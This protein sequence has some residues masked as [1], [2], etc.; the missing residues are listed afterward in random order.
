MKNLFFLFV[1]MLVCMNVSSFGQTRR[2]EIIVDGFEGNKPLKENSVVIVDYPEKW[3]KGIWEE[4]YKGETRKSFLKRIKKQS[5]E[6]KE[7]RIP[8]KSYDEDEDILLVLPIEYQPVYH[9]TYASNVLK[10]KREPLTL[11]EFSD[12][13][14][15]SDNNHEVESKTSTVAA[16]DNNTKKNQAMTQSKAQM[17][18]LF[19][20]CLA[21][22]FFIFSKVPLLWSKKK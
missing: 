14:M 9:K 13:L 8:K 3:M 5:E 19:I 10:S 7:S 15:M 2:D 4:A 11:Q 21:M 16:P 22:L 17:I 1:F 6:V 12:S 18:V 20:F